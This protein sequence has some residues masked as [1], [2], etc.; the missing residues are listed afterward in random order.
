MSQQTDNFYNKFSIFYP[1]VDI[2]LR[3]QKRKLFQ[4]INAQPVG[5]LL[6]IGVGNGMHLH[7]YKRHQIIGID[8]SINMLETAKKQ[9]VKNV[10]LIKMDGES[11]SF[12]D[13]HFDFIVI[14]H[15]I[16]VVDD[17]EKLLEE[18]HRVL[19]PTGKVY[20]LNH[21][22][23]ENWLKYVD[24][25]FQKISKLFHFKSVFHIN[26][27]T[28]IKKFQLIKEIGFAPFSYFKLLIYGKA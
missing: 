25:S 27:L 12:E 2:F 24:L 9:K 18:V 16:A 8:T 4:E 26:S 7:F 17:P 15:V 10:E 6:E 28:T 22:T 5:S 20:I 1:L 3:P 23:P 21:F 13:Q 19:K 11:L 14:S